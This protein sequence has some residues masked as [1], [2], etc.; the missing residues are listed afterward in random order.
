MSLL[1]GKGAPQMY[2]KST[3]GNG[4]FNKLC[5]SNGPAIG[6]NMEFGL[7]FTPKPNQFQVD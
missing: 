2:L 7:S 6:R 5:L 1:Y 4:L 3:G